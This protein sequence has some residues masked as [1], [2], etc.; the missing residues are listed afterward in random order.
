MA[1]KIEEIVVNTDVTT[2]Q[3]LFPYGG[4]P[5][6]NFAAA[7]NYGSALGKGARAWAWQCAAIDFTA[8]QQWHGLQF[9]EDRRNHVFWHSTI[10]KAAEF[11]SQRFRAFRPDN[12]SNQALGFGRVAVNGDDRIAH[13]RMS[14]QVCLNLTRLYPH[15]TQFDLLIHPTKIFNRAVGQHSSQIASSKNK[16]RLVRPV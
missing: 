9:D 8:G 5:F 14:I 15:A 7:I 6:L 16:W 2:S 12:I 4:Q 10:Q 3:H 1:A 11:V 13:E